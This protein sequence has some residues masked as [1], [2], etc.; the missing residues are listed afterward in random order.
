MSLDA[1]AIVDRRRLKRRISLWRLAA[2]A[3]LVIAVFGIAFASS[4][5]SGLLLGS[6]HIAALDISGVITGERDK[7]K[8]L[9]KI[10]KSSKAKALILRIDSPGGTTAGS[11]ILFE[12][13][14]AVADKKPVV[15]VL[16]TVAASGGYITALAAD[17]IVA[18]GNTITGSIGVIFQWAEVSKALSTL[19]IKYDEIKSS[20]LKAAPSMFAEA[21]DEARSVTRSMVMEGYEWFVSLVA[22]RRPFDLS[23]ARSLSD[24]RVY[25]GRQAVAARLIDKLGG[26][27]E[28]KTWLQEEKSLDK[29]LKIVDWSDEEDSNLDLVSRVINLTARALGILPKD[30][31]AFTISSQGGTRR[32]DGL[33]SLWHPQLV[34]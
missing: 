14:R 11:E 15:A 19:G 22:E 29:D 16:E 32:L 21:S 6:S 24:G 10:A 33:L 3:A 7:V 5:R 23:T 26:E 4:G 20:P 12:E 31:T 27:K 8:I 9:Q 2:V 18:R 30:S 1:E 13:I 17:H 28:A 34:N 25:T